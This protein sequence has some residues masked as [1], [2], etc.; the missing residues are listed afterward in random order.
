M[1]HL[2]TSLIKLDQT[3][4]QVTVSPWRLSRRKK[5]PNPGISYLIYNFS[6]LLIETAFT[7]FDKY[8]TQMY[9]YKYYTFH[10]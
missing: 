10:P 6:D 1:S 7:P 4:K 8:A 3:E 5:I 2:F 9:T